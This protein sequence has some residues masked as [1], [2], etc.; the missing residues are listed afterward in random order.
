[1]QNVL[2][3]KIAANV[4]NCLCFLFIAIAADA[5]VWTMQEF[6][7]CLTFLWTLQKVKHTRQQFALLVDEL[8]S[9]DSTSDYQATVMTAIKCIVNTPQDVRMRVKLRNQFF[10]E[11]Y[12]LSAYTGI[13]SRL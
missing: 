10:G 9:G 7:L 1:M 3:Y 6:N 2:Y 12:R 13:A 4:H 8:Q 11:L 5:C